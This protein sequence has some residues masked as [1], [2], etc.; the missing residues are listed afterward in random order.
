MKATSK[1]QWIRFHYVITLHLSIFNQT[2]IH[3]KILSLSRLHQTTANDS[4]C[5]IMM[6]W[7]KLKLTSNGTHVLVFFPVPWTWM[8][9]QPYMFIYCHSLF[10]IISVTFC[11]CTSAPTITLHCVTRLS[12]FTHLRPVSSDPEILNSEVS[13]MKICSI[14]DINI[15][16]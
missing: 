1:F 5:W 13:Y 9:V 3:A 2:T 14:I 12:P 7:W 16:I 10:V 8:N 4:N 6:Y 15:F 11:L